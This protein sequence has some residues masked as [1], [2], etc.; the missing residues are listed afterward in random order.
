MSASAEAQ[1]RAIRTLAIWRLDPVRFALDELRFKPDPWQTQVLD[2]FSDPELWRLALVA[3][4]GPGKSALLSVLVWNFF[5]TRPNAKIAV[6]SIT[7]DNL[8]DGLWSELKK[9]GN[10]SSYIKRTFK[11]GAGRIHL[12]NGDPDL[13]FISFR[14]WSKKASPEE[15]EETL[16]GLHGDYC[17]MVLDEAG[18]IPSAVLSAAD[19]VLTT[20]GTL[21]EETGVRRESKVIIAGNPTIPEGPL[22]DTLNDERGEWDV[23][24]VTGDPDDPARAPRVGK[25]WALSQIRKHGLDS[26]WVQ[27]NV[28]GQF[29]KKLTE[30]VVSVFDFTRAIGKT[31]NDA[32]EP[33]RRGKRT[34]G[35]DVA[36]RGK[37]RT[38]LMFRDGDFVEKIEIHEGKGLDETKEIVREAHIDWKSDETRIDDNGVGGSVVDHLTGATVSEHEYLD[39]IVPVNSCET[40]FSEYHLNL[41]SEMAAHVQERFRR[42]QISLPRNVRHT[43]LQREATTIWFVFSKVGA[44]RRLVDKDEYSTKKTGSPDVYDAL[45][46]AF[47]DGAGSA[48]SGFASEEA[49]PVRGG[50]GQV[51]KL[52]S[53]QRQSVRI[54]A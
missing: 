18:G 49:V 27:T 9:W 32:G 10:R 2:R 29:P 47:S 13:W 36:R 28:F 41:R 14:K 37:N 34:I 39:G 42:G 8:R 40:A 7:E 12:R 24:Q 38:V 23:V 20:T 22:W 46:L 54:R 51:S 26:P 11:I 44:K 52:Q 17:M 30:G 53:G 1:A 4:K 43:T 21:N 15:Q 35:V 31:H 48:S 6:T 19:G 45:A 16:A 25:E 5:V 33:L 50:L 3:C